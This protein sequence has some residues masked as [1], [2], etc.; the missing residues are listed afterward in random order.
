VESLTR[1]VERLRERSTAVSLHEV[2]S[3]SVPVRL[4]DAFCWLFSPFL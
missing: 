4:R 2:D 3:R 1:H